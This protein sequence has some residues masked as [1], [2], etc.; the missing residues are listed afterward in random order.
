MSGED[1]AARKAQLRREMR[2][3]RAG[4]SVDAA[5]RADRSTRLWRSVLGVIAARVHT[6][7]PAVML[8]ESFPTE[9]DTAKWLADAAER[10]WSV[11]VPEVDGPELRV[12]PGDADPHV[13]DV[14]VA[15]G[16]AFTWD[17]RRLGQ[18]GGHYDRFIARLGPQCLTVGV[19]YAEQLVD[20]LPTQ[21][22]DRTVDVV[23]T[24]AGAGSV[25]RR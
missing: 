2:L 21:A 11:F 10:S 14:V 17:G 24:D 15:P 7:V 8:F 19:C 22:H 3:L 4:I 16:L 13:L 23:V 18:G 5:E 1:L 9:P 20:E 6:A 12:M 25:P